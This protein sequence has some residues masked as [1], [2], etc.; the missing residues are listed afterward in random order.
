MTTVEY[1]LDT[2]GGLMDQ[3]QALIAPPKSDDPKEKNKKPGIEHP[4]F[5]RPGKGHNHDSCDACGEGGDLICCDKCPS[6]FHL[7]CHDPPLE[8]QDIPRGDWLCHSCKYTK[9][10]NTVPQLRSKRSNSTPAGTSGLKPSKKPKLTALEMLIEAANSMNPKQFELPRSMSFPCIFPGTDKAEIPYSKIGRKNS[11]V[12]KDHEKGPSGIIPLPAKKCSECRK[13]CRM[14]PLISCDFCELFYH[15]DC[16]DPPLTS[17][18]SGRWMC[19]K[20]V[21]H[22]LDSK[23]LTSISATERVKIWDKF[24]GPVNQDS[25]KLEF[26]RKVHRRNPP[27]RI[28]KPLAPKN[29]VLVPDMVKY[30]YK[31]PVNLLPR[32]RDVLRIECINKKMK[33]E[34]AETVEEVKVEEEEDSVQEIIK[35]EHEPDISIEESDLNCDIIKS[36]QKTGKKCDGFNLEGSSSNNISD[37]I[38][39]TPVNGYVKNEHLN[40]GYFEK[41][42]IKKE[43]SFISDMISG[44]TTEMELELKQLDDR[45]LKL[46]AYQRIQQLINSPSSPNNLFSPSFKE[47]FRQMPLPS[48][49][50]TPA[51]I[52]RIS[53]VFSSPKKKVKPKSTIRARAMLCPVVSKHFYNVRTTEVDP[54]DVRHDASFMGF[55]PTVSARFPEAVAMRYRVLNVGKGSANEVDLEKF[56][57]CNFIVPK[58]A[59]IFYDEYTKHYELINYSPNGT[60][61]NNVLYSNNI[62]TKRPELNVSTDEKSANVEMQVREIIDKKRKINRARKSSFESKMSAVDYIDKMECCCSNNP[63][64]LKKGWEGSAILNHGSL[65][66]F[67]CVSFVFSI[68]ECTNL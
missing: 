39:W 41:E 29:S 38:E 46:L 7:G 12:S 30:H 52:D 8:E 1:D 24:T 20:H 43:H 61:V 31:K 51:D 34:Q 14:A 48:E 10:L 6:S 60:Y 13:S 59:V 9:N 54:T 45:L 67:G 65:L 58:H 64:E 53:R 56:G 68:V 50:L 47:K 22:C 11:K 42:L 19:P 4:Y 40:G 33:N 21:E 44:I 57:Y 2:S 15:L 49:L 5:K 62:L 23:L 27:F 25:I 37:N 3:I 26:F 32:L 55:R 35:T 18:P 28:K 16:L 63:E 17:A 36:N 66:R